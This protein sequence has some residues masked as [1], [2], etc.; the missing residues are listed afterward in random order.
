MHYIY[1]HISIIVHVNAKLFVYYV[2]S[3]IGCHFPCLMKMVDK[4]TRHCA[5]DHRVAGSI[6]DWVPAFLAKM[7]KFIYFSHTEV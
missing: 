4:V 2:G 1:F 7:L 5:L 6:P 3:F